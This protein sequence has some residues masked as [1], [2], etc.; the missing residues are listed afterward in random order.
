MVLGKRRLLLCI[1]YSSEKRQL[2]KQT[3]KKGKLLCVTP[4]QMTYLPLVLAQNSIL[5]NGAQLSETLNLSVM[6]ADVF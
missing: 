2:Q 4:P 5:V 1:E 3:L 6:K